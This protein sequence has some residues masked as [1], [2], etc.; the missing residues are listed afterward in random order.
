MNVVIKKLDSGL[1]SM[2]GIAGYLAQS[3]RSADYFR[4][5]I[6]EQEQGDRLVLVALADGE[7]A[8]HV[9]VKWRSDHPY[10]L[11]NSIPE[12]NDLWVN[13]GFRRRGIA[14]ALMDE[15]ECI[16]FSRSPVAGL[17]VG[18][19]ADYGPA[20]QMYAH[21]GYVPDGHGLYYGTRP[22]KPGSRVTVDDHL[23]LF[24][25]KQRPAVND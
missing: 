13:A 8:G 9:T 12:I 4:K 25:V 23:A 19:Y 17:G 2:T 22:V 7:L 16:I 21:R 10:F 15:A 20:Q 3:S 5:L 11:E 1:L 24:L 18:L 6:A 14:A